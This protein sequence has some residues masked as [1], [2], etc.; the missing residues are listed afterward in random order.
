MAFGAGLPALAGLDVLL[1]AGPREIASGVV[2]FDGESVFVFANVFLVMELGVFPAFMVRLSGDAGFEVF[3][4]AILE[5]FESAADL[6]AP[7]GFVKALS[8]CSLSFVLPLV[9]G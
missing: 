2:G 8:F 4:I 5:G 6:V 9:S 1:R 7:E 3:E